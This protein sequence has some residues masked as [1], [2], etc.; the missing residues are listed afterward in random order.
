MASKS[1]LRLPFTNFFVLKKRPA[2]DTQKKKMRNFAFQTG[3]VDLLFHWIEIQKPFSPLI[4]TPW[5]GLYIQINSTGNLVCTYTL[6]NAAITNDGVTPKHTHTIRCCTCTCCVFCLPFFIYIPFD[7]VV[8]VVVFWLVTRDVLYILHIFFFLPF[9]H[10]WKSQSRR[11]TMGGRFQLWKVRCCQ[12]IMMPIDA[13]QSKI[14]GHKNTSGSFIFNYP[15][16]K[17]RQIT[18]GQMDMSSKWDEF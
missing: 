5:R 15:S 7:V 2:I 12:N 4:E 13:F 3:R 8:V 1:R 6:K 18:S 16:A 9:I 14:W 17:C 11:H 10:A